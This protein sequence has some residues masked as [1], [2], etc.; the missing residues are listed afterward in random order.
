M[1]TASV[2]KQIVVA[3]V[4]RDHPSG[5]RNRAGFRFFIKPVAVLAT[6]DEVAQ[7][8]A[9]KYLKIHRRLHRAWFEALGMEYTEQNIKRF[10]DQDPAPSALSKLAGFVDGLSLIKQ[11]DIF[12]PG[13][14]GEQIDASGDDGKNAPPQTTPVTKLAITVSRDEAVAK[15]KEKGMIE[16]KDFDPNASRDALVTLYNSL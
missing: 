13:A 10:A 7:I 3:S 1:S 2:E 6:P 16:G 12:D 11:T 8:A 4:N 14:S 15:L 5:Q 9:D